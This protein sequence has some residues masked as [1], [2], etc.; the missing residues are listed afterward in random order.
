MAVLRQLGATHVIVHEAAYLDAEGRDTT[1]ALRRM[2]A[3][4][5]F[6][7]GPDTLLALP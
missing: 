2:G 5:A 4:E 6:R 7:E 1:T 3:T